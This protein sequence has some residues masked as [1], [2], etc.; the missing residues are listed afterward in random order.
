MFLCLTEAD[1]PKKLCEPVPLKLYFYPFS[2]VSTMHKT[3]H[4]SMD[5]FLLV[6]LTKLLH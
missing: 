1:L 3:Y 4:F 2:D 5:M 6:N